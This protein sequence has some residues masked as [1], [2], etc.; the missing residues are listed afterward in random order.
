[1][2]AP[3]FNRIQRTMTSSTRQRLG[4][5]KMALDSLLTLVVLLVADYARH[6]IP[7]GMRIGADEVY[8]TPQVFVIVGGV[9]VVVFRLW[10][11]YDPRN[12]SSLGRE[13]EATFFATTFALF[14][15]ASCFYL[16]KI[17]D[18]SRLLYLYLYLL[19]LVVLNG[20]RIALHVAIQRLGTPLL[21]Q[22][23]VLLVGGT[24][25]DAAFIDHIQRSRHY[26]LVGLVNAAGP[27]PFAPGA[28]PVIGRVA[29]L[30]G[31]VHR[32]AID[33][34][35]VAAPPNRRSEI[36]NLALDL[37]GEVVRLRVV[38]DV[39]EILT[40][41]ARVEE[42]AGIPLIDIEEPA[43]RGLNRVLKRALDFVG[44]TIMLVVFM[45]VMAVIALLI[46]L[47]S[48]GPVLYVQERVGQGGRIFKMCKFRSMVVNAER[49]LPRLLEPKD[50]E[51]P[52]YKIENDPR[53]TRVGRFLRRTS[54]DE[55][56]Q[57]FNVIKGEMSL[58]GP[59]PEEVWVVQRYEPRH[60]QRLLAKPG[61]T[62]S[63]Q[64]SGRG[65]L[66]LEERLKLEL[67]YIE[68]YSVW[69]D[70]K[71]LVKTIPVVVSGKGAY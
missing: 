35:I 47:D 27:D 5:T 13:L 26:D 7:L 48:P 51:Q 21:V 45:P 34:V 63:M 54:L 19:D 52:A 9:W 64:I 56:P 17:W 49:L 71:I 23:R 46:K 37:S 43:I 62:G 24:D 55:L 44:A 25:L 58:V 31:L 67:S 65:D 18:F 38:P 39:L 30:G 36:A 69:E 12:L 57:L 16:F 11:V 4:R 29:D 28:V 42:V 33:E 53:V 60:R 50:L 66:S 8:L 61:M 41:R 10:G 68:N 70:I 40:T 15:L 59:R 6:R 32:H 20:Y 3:S 1:M 22:K 2:A 14:T